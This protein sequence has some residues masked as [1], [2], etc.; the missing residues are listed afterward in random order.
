MFCSD[1]LPLNHHTYPEGLLNLRVAP[2]GC[3][4]ATYYGQYVVALAF[5]PPAKNVMAQI[6]RSDSVTPLALS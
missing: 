5:E 3:R 6:D 4:V 1:Y 2:G